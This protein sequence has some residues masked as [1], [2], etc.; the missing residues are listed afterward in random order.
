MLHTFILDC[1]SIAFVSM[2][3]RFY[4]D[5]QGDLVEQPK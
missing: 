3:R 2:V 1:L 5:E 4:K